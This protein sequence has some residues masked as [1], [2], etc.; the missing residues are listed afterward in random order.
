VRVVNEQTTSGVYEFYEINQTDEGA[1]NILIT[2]VMSDPI[3]VGLAGQKEEISLGGSMTVTASVPPEVGNV[4]YV[5]Y[6]NGESKATGSSYTFGSDLPIG[7]YRLDV[8]AFTTDGI[9]AGSTTTT[10]Q[11]VETELPQF[12]INA[13]TGDESQ[14]DL[15]IKSSGNTFM[16]DATAASNGN[17]GYKVKLSGVEGDNS[18]GKKLVSNQYNDISLK[19]SAYFPSTQ[20]PMNNQS[21]KRYW[22]LANIADD[23]TGTELASLEMSGSS[24]QL[25]V[26]QLVYAS[27]TIQWN[28]VKI[29]EPLSLDI[30]HFFEIR[31]RVGGNGTASVQLVID[32]VV[33]ANASGYAN[34]NY[35]LESVITGCL[36]NTK[37]TVNGE[38]LYLDDIQIN[39]SNL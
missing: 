1:I 14:W 6:I 3:V 24:T 12:T 8:T 7:V 25:L 29:D 17:Y 33:K 5:W 37:Y 4:V 34:N 31:C 30:W 18:Y 2:P 9:R 35:D 10:I 26:H 13:E 27:N 22:V 36:W 16:A 38:Y 39:T 28:L 32:G 21:T 23:S 19:F 20:Y 15:L 11:V